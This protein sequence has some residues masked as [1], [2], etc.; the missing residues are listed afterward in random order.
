MSLIW[1]RI[2]C[3][4]L[5]AVKKLVERTVRNIAETYKVATIAV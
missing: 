5:L 2:F 3:I 4:S 1:S